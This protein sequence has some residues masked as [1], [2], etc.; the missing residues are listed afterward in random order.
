MKLLD[1]MR[2][3]SLDDDAMAILVGGVTA[4]AVKKWK[5]GERT[6]RRTELQKISE[7]TAGNVT[8]NDF[9]G[10]ASSAPAEPERTPS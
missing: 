7:V 8:A 10:L 2:D 9:A 1:W 3:N 6:P 4:H 5:Y